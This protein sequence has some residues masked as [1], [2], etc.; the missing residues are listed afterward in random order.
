MAQL[1]PTLLAEVLSPFKERILSVDGGWAGPELDPDPEHG[2]LLLAGDL[3]G[4]VFTFTLPRPLLRC[5]Q[6]HGGCGS[7]SSE[8]RD[9]PPATATPPPAAVAPY[10]LPLLSALR[11]AHSR[12]PV[13]YVRVALQPPP[14]QTLAPGALCMAS[15]S[16][17][18]SLVQYALLSSSSGSSGG[19][20]GSICSPPHLLC[21]GREKLSCMTMVVAEV[22]LEEEGGAG[23]RQAQ[24]EV[25]AEVQ[26]REQGGA[27]TRQRVGPGGGPRVLAGFQSSYFVVYDMTAQ[28]EVGACLWLDVGVW[29]GWVDRRV[30]GRTSFSHV[31][32]RPCLPPCVCRCCVCRVAAGAAPMPS[33]LK[34]CRTWSLC[35][36]T[37]TCCTSRAEAKEAAAPTRPP[38]YSRLGSRDP[39]W[40]QNWILSS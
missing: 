27:G 5:I 9:L 23:C 24:G 36:T 18:G 25:R 1:Q 26:S 37:T 10:Q 3:A 38:R 8:F 35:S 11:G 6:Q 30:G 7:S 31:P 16:R 22:F 29:C 4:N 17:D 19:S 14:G 34:A 32:H 20:S 33:T 2:A 40:I 12:N 13:S 39:L 21:R 15:A 28:A